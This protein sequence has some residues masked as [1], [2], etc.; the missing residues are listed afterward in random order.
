MRDLL[1]RGWRDAASLAGRGFVP[2]WGPFTATRC[3]V[4]IDHVLIDNRLGV[5]SFD[6]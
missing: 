5:R 6:A 3:A 2:T 4:T 1:D